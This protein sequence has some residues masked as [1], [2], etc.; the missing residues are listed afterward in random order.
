MAHHYSLQ[1]SAPTAY[2]HWAKPGA[3]EA[4][5]MSSI[6]RS[7]MATACAPASRKDVDMALTAIESSR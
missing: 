3:T 6:C 5:S 1:Y 2:L 4:A 7:R